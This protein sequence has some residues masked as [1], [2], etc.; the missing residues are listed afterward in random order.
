LANHGGAVLGQ[1]VEFTESSPFNMR[2]LRRWGRVDV[3]LP[4]VVTDRRG[5]P[6]L[7]ADDSI[8]R[9]MAVP[10]A[11]ALAALKE[12]VMLLKETSLTMCGVRKSTVSLMV[13]F[14]CDD[15]GCEARD[16]VTALPLCKI[17]SL[18]MVA[19]RALSCRG[20]SSAR[21]KCCGGV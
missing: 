5:L 11:V 12:L 10:L 20:S 16:G 6:R 7:F 17:T 2:E 14:P 18:P 13:R 4:P 21:L 1:S 3:V 19:G 9:E 8:G 15:K